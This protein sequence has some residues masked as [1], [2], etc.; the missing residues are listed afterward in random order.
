MLGCTTHPLGIDDKEWNQLTP[1]QKL[2][3][4]KQDEQNKLEQKRMSLREWNQKTE[5]Q[6]QKDVNEGMIAYL[7]P[8]TRY[9]IGGEM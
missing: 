1:E 4:H 7:L 9:C 6:L 3:A 2:E 8:D 5:D